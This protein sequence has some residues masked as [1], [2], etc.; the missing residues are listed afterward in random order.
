MSSIFLPL[1]PPA[2]LISSTASSMPFLV[3]WPKLD[4]W[5]VKS[6]YTPT[7]IVSPEVVEDG[8]PFCTQ[9][10]EKNIE[11]NKVIAKR[12]LVIV[13]SQIDF[14]LDKSYQAPP[15]RLTPLAGGK[16]CYEAFFIIT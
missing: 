6:P 13:T 7:L 8:P 4:V 14:C 15:S 1:T 16:I 12:I 10:K 11:V 2:A 9:A 3:D 5:P